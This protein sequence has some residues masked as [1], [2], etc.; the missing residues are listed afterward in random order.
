M[1]D[2]LYLKKNG[3]FVLFIEVRDQQIADLEAELERLRQAR[4][5]DADLAAQNLKLYDNLKAENERLRELAELFFNCKWYQF[6]KKK[7]IYKWRD[8]LLNKNQ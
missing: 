1:S 2:K 5:K 4:F 6:K 3:E 7:A 8:E